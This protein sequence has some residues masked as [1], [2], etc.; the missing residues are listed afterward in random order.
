MVRK[1]KK[2]SSNKKKT[3]QKERL[4]ML[5]KKGLLILS[6]FACLAFL[7][8]LYRTIAG[9]E[10][11][12]VREIEIRGN[13]HLS[14]EEL[15]IMTNIERGNILKIG[16][17]SLRNSVL[18][19]PWV[20]EAVVRRE[21]PGIIRVSLTERVPEA[22]IDYGDSF[23][24]VDG[25]GVIIERIRDRGGYLLPLISGVDLSENRLGENCTSRG[26]IEGLALL[27]F[28]K[29][30]GL[31]RDDI[32]LVAQD[33]EDLAMNLSGRQ[34][35]VGAGN[36]QE[37][38]NRLNEIEKELGRKGVLSNLIDIRF[39]GKVIVIPVSESKL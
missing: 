18:K 3:S 19:S 27:R 21:L 31:G 2:K 7:F 38:F 33:P 24:L 20:K 30:K 4:S 5:F 34:I 12:K 16:L 28:L 6:A 22:M 23:Y 15:S 13:H 37:K 10:I 26:L 29:E 36:F 11:L 39:P 9:L 8:L 1:K 35:K 32:E 14:A 25:E 17:E